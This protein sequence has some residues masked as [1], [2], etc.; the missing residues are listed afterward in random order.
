M[1][2]TNPPARLLLTISVMKYPNLTSLLILNQQSILSLNWIYLSIHKDSKLISTKRG[3]NLKDIIGIVCPVDVDDLPIIQCSDKWDVLDK[4]VFVLQ[5]LILLKSSS[6]YS[7]SILKVLQT[8]VYSDYSDDQ[9]AHVILLFTKE[10]VEWFLR[11]SYLCDISVSIRKLFI[12]ITR[13]NIVKYF[14]QFESKWR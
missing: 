12:T 14:V 7:G 2:V 1:N 9:F 5:N 3:C 4:E 8:F 13:L 11:E 6:I 10:F